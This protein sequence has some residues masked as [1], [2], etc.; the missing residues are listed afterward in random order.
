VYSMVS[1]MLL[2]QKVLSERQ[3]SSPFFGT[4]LIQQSRTSP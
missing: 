1:G 3:G 4:N 2:N